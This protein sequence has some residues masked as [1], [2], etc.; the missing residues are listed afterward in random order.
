VTTDETRVLAL[1]PERILRLLSDG[2]VEVEGLIPW[3]SNATLLVTVCDEELSSLAVYK[4]QDGERPLWDFRSGTLGMRETAAYLL[5]E[6][7]GWGLIPPTVMREGPYGL[8]SVQFYVHCQEDAHFFTVQEDPGYDSDLK[9]LAVFDVISNNADRKAGHCLLD[10]EGKLWAIDNALCFHEEAKLRTVIWDYA[11]E[12]LP[13]QIAADLR[14]LRPA[15]EA[16]APVRNALD[17]LLSKAEVAALHRRLDRL[18]EAGRFPEPGPE[19][20][21]P[22]PLF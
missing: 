7:L 21:V 6:A 20:A 11:R 3:S 8:G 19:R 15:L 17:R 14:A 13:P 18:L 10:L 16:G 1:S 12:T 22:W 9:R 2:E 4:P 5:S